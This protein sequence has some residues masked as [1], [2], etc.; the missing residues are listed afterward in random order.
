VDSYFVKKD[1][2]MDQELNEIFEYMNIDPIEEWRCGIK[3]DDFELPKKAAERYRD[4]K[5]CIQF[6]VQGEQNTVCST[7][8][9]FCALEIRRFARFLKVNCLLQWH[10]MTYDPEN[11]PSKAQLQVSNN[12]D[13]PDGEWSGWGYYFSIST[14]NFRK[15]I[16][17]Y[18]DLDEDFEVAYNPDAD[19]LVSIGLA[20]LEWT[21]K[22]QVFCTLENFQEKDK[23]FPTE[24]FDDFSDET[25]H[26]KALKDQCFVIETA[27]KQ[28]VV[29]PYNKAD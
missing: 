22:F 4:E 23:K 5:C 16:P 9:P 11:G 26:A 10:G 12:D 1:V 3:T 18:F 15:A 21:C 20:E 8:L 19:P 13:V 7:D 14:K 29:C 17:F 27:I 28:H 25:D 6:D 24:D 2:L